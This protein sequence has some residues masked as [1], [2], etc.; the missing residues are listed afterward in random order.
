M[1]QNKKRTDR[2]LRVRVFHS[3]DEENLAEHRRRARMT[4]QE[5]MAEFAVLQERL[6]GEEWTTKPLVRVATWEKVDW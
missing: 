3:F 6:W 1:N 5:R 4:P 2:N